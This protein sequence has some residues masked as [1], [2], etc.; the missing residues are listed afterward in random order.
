MLYH[1]LIPGCGNPGDTLM[2][3]VKV[4]E[5][6]EIIPTDLDDLIIVPFVTAANL[7]VTKLLGNST[8]LSSAQ[9]KE[10]ERWLT[11]HLIACTRER[12][13]KSE[14]AKDAKIEYQGVTGEGLMSTFYG[15]TCMVLDT[16]GVLKSK[17]GKR[18]VTLTAVTSFE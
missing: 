14:S 3:R 13:A 1:L 12:Q 9:L 10:I 16:S 5:V 11:A 8:V 15:Q 18:V 2:A 17:M 6:K 7:T 4:S